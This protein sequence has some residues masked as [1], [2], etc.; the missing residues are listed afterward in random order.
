MAISHLIVC[1]HCDAVYRRLLLVDGE[2]ALCPHCGAE[3]YHSR[4]VN[5]DWMLAMTLTAAVVFVIANAYP[6]AILDLQGRSNAARLWD[7]VLITYDS[8]MGP[9]AIVAAGTAF[10][11]P[12]VEIILLLYVLLPLRAGWVASEFPLAMR[13]L[14]LAR[15]WSMVEVFMIGTLVSVVKLQGY[16]DV[17]LQPGMWGFAVLTVLMAALQQHHLHELW[18]YADNC[19]RVRLHAWDIEP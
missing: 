5:L 3:L 14:R 19:R 17:S 12:L 11:L 15:P 7:A 1:E 2:T 8:G 18:D 16:A 9:I 4:R 6:I 13:L 10:F